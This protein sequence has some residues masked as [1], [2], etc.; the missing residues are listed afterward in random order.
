MFP[1]SRTGWNSAR[2]RS[3]DSQSFTTKA[4]LAPGSRSPKK[5]SGLK[6]TRLISKT[7][8]QTKTKPHGSADHRRREQLG[9]RGEGEGVILGEGVGAE[10]GRE[11]ERGYFG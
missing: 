10:G 11:V 2:L 5:P 3:E 4:D 8:Q 1:E 7:N 6:C 9:R